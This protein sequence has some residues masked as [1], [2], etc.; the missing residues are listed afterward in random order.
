VVVLR[1]HFVFRHTIVSAPLEPREVLAGRAIAPNQYRV[2][3]GLLVAALSPLVGDGLADF[4]VPLASI[5]LCTA[6]LAAVL[7]AETRSVERASVG[8]V[9]FAGV[10]GEV[11]TM[12]R[13]HD[14]YLDVAFALLA[15]AIASRPRPRWG[16][17]A[18]LAVLGAL[19]RETWL[20]ALSGAACARAL[21]GRGLATRED[22]TKR[23]A[24]GL[25]VAGALSIAALAGVR[26]YFG[27]RAYRIFWM[28]P[29][30]LVNLTD[31]G[32]LFTKGLWTWPALVLAYVGALLGRTAAQVPFVVGYVLPNLVASFLFANW[33]EPRIFMATTALLVVG[34]LG[35][36]DAMSSPPR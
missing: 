18:V 15:L 36:T 30:N 11:F 21:R 20:F 19:N 26:L 28:A 12:K 35:A 7:V 22:E 9:A 13:Y 29:I 8:L 32:L 5:V 23:D 27:E 16:W 31:P 2:L 1:L 14:M 6:T 10:A 34:L 3:P 4:L 24:I 17:F 25:G 33:Y